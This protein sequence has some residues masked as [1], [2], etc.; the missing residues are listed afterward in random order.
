LVGLTGLTLLFLFWKGI[1]FENFKYALL[2]LLATLFYGIN[3]NTVAH[4]LKEINPLHIATISLAFMTIPTAYVLWQQNF[5]H[6]AFSESSVQWALVEAAIL[7]VVGSAIATAIFYLLINRA[8]GLFASL[9]TYGVPFI[10]IFW[11]I[12]DGEK[13]TMKQIGCLVIILFGVYLVNKRDKTE[14]KTKIRET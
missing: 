7:G 8:G 2:I 5:F 9:V 1:N 13:I 14:E 10:G 6:L 12:L 3:I 11:G 4:F